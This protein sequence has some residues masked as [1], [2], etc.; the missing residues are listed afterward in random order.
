MLL[1]ILLLSVFMELTLLVS[2]ICFQ[3]QL[4]QELAL[5][6]RLRP[7]RKR[8]FMSRLEAKLKGLMK[9]T[10]PRQHKN[11]K[12]QKEEVPIHRKE[13]A[14]A[15]SDGPFKVIE[16]VGSN[17]YKLRL[18]G[19]VAILATFNIVDLSLTWRIPLKAPQIWSQFLLKKGGLC[20]S[21]S[22]RTAKE[23]PRSRGSRS[24]GL[25]WPNTSIILL[26]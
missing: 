17:A 26:Y 19:D 1:D 16:K 5:R 10:R 11:R 13:Q 8:R 23:L 14:Y 6:L 22:P 12:H 20:S 4:N 7:R 25:E 18:A 2:W 24:R 9:H 15:R 21:T 3:F